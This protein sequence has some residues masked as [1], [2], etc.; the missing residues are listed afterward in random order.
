MSPS[1]R[2]RPRLAVLARRS[3]P[4]LA[5]GLLAVPATADAGQR[6]PAPPAELQIP[7]RYLQQQ[8]GWV[9]CSSAVPDL[10]CARVAVP[11]DWARPDS[12]EDIQIAI[13]KLPTT[14]GDKRGMVTFNPGGPGASGLGMPIGTG[15]VHPQL[16][17][18][19]DLV[20][21]DPRG[22]GSSRPNV[23]CQTEDE[24]RAFFGLDGRDRSPQN[25][26][27]TL[28]LSDKT[29]ADCRTRTGALQPYVT[30]W[31]TVRDME[32][33]RRLL[34]EP[35]MSYIGYSAGTWLGAHY[36]QTF[37]QHADRF[38]LDS[39]VD[40]TEPWSENGN[41]QP[42]G[43]ERRF[44]EDFLPWM[45]RY[46]RLYH[47]GTSAREARTRYEARRRA[48]QA[49]P[50]QI[51]GITIGPADYDN[52]VVGVMYSKD[53]FPV[54]AQALA[55]IERP[56]ALT[57]DDEAA[58]QAVFGAFFDATT[59]AGY[60]TITCG[61][62]PWSRD[63][64]DLVRLSERLGRRY[65]LLGYTWAANPCPFWRQP[66]GTMQRIDGRGVPATL[67]VNSTHDPATPYEGARAAHRGFR[68]S[69]FVTIRD[70]GDHGIYGGNPC[71]DQIALRFLIEGVLP[72]RDSS[73]P[74]V[75]LPDPTAAP[76]PQAKRAPESLAQQA[77]RLHEQAESPT[78]REDRLGREVGRQLDAALASR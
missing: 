49:Q 34:D 3:A 31:Q 53:G 44:Q 42:L 52:G 50:L 47:Y 71:F 18:H 58:I 38:V 48:L 30:T 76:A 32:F 15:L 27:R 9:A 77:E 29:A 25:I 12:G 61:D 64:S 21:F 8:I 33:V 37:P 22:M 67:M 17:E 23:A 28:Q 1:R 51:A 63:P 5:A 46:D 74:G 2:L 75:P 72:R 26:A 11:R 56:D 62:T 16:R 69:R 24:Y 55:A 20:G 65:P 45:A 40:F 7:A 41:L 73:C 10:R 35:R 70:E 59:Y 54:L 19:Y 13:S 60:F 4:L 66:Y 39:N 6:P 36:V 78:E 68:G 43:F 57:P 14:G